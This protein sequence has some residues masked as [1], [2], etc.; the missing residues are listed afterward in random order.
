MKTFEWTDDFNTNLPSVDQQH[1]HLVD[2]I[3][4]L[5]EMFGDHQVDRAQMKLLFLELADYAKRHFDDEERLMQEAGID[6]RHI[7]RHQR[8][9]SRFLDDVGAIY[10]AGGEHVE[11]SGGDM[12]DYLTHWL[13]FHILGMDQDMSRQIMAMKEGA[14]PAEAFDRFE[15]PKDEAIEPLLAALNRMLQKLSNR[16]QELVDLN[17]TLE[18]R[19][20]ERTEELSQANK[21]L[22]ALSLTDALTGLANRRH[23]ILLLET[24]WTESREHGEPISALMIDADYFKQVND[25]YGHDAGDDVLIAL[26]RELKNSIR[27]DD[28]VFRLGGDEF[29]VLCPA[30]D[31]HGAM[32]VADTL[33]KCVADMKV[34]TGD[35]YWRNSVSIGVSTSEPG[36]ERFEDVI[37]AADDGLYKAKGAGRGCARSASQNA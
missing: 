21:E 11:S 1:R 12:L 37:K 13:S 14:A 32:Q 30:T 8:T 2:L 19:V 15:R 25:N 5:G 7:Q 29:L 26:A 34:A 17:Q 23:A 20:A 31:F 27:T 33:L 6:R 4:R 24:L 36:M 22:K 16:N 18:A 9:H 28:L 3:N 35:G 10:A